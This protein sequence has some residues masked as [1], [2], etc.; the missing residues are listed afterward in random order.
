LCAFKVSG[1]KPFC[2]GSHRYLPED[3]VGKA[4]AKDYSNYAPPKLA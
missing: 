1:E 4:C 2:D 3:A